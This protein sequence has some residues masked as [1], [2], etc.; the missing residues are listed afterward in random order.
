MKHLFFLTSLLLILALCSC[1]NNTQELESRIAALEDSLSKLSVSES[2]KNSNV[3]DYSTHS[4]SKEESG[5]NTF[6]NS[7]ITFK[8]PDNFIVSDEEIDESGFSSMNVTET[9]DALK[10]ITITYATNALFTLMSDY[11]ESDAENDLE[12]F[13]EGMNEYYSNISTSAI[14]K[15]SIGV[16]DGYKQSFQ[17]TLLGVKVAGDC[18]IAYKNNH[19]I[20][21]MTQS[22]SNQDTEILK[23]IMN[24]ISFCK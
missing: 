11:S 14:S 6:N 16:F 8:Y 1:K 19:V 4:I 17:A 3:H 12:G 2:N 13:R 20:M 18:F 23:Q 21:L 10:C 24:T 15:S 7:T 22:E 5:W 9:G